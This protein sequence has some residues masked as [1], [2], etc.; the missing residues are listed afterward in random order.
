[1]S[2]YLF[3]MRKINKSLEIFQVIACI[4]YYDLKCGFRW[5]EYVEQNFPLSYTIWAL[6]HGKVSNQIRDRTAAHLIDRFQ[7]SRVKVLPFLLLRALLLGMLNLLLL[8]YGNGC[9]MDAEW[10]QNGWMQ[11]G[12]SVSI[13]FAAFAWGFWL[14]WIKDITPPPPVLLGKNKMLLNML[15]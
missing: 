2:E 7:I 14:F 9:R 4:G 10:M 12:L 1:M 13:L 6:E 3:R 5:E 15:C 8:I 11:K